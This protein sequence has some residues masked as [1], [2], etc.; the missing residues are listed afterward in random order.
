MSQNATETL[1]INRKELPSAS[2]G[3]PPV[4]SSPLYPKSLTAEHTLSVSTLVEQC[5][6]EI[7]AYRRGEPSNESFGLELLRRAIVQG[8]QDAWIGLQQCFDETIRFWL[9]SHPHREVAC[10]LES[11]NTYV[12]LALERFWQATTGQQIEFKTLGGALAYLRASLHGAILDTLRAYSRPREVALPE[13]G[14]FGEPQVEDQVEGPEVWEALQAIL[15]N[16]R[17]QRLAYLLYHC[18]LKPREIVRFCSQEWSDIHE[19]Y[20]LRRNIQERILRNVDKLRW[21][22]GAH[23][24]K[25]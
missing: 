12:A 3:L 9:Y 7:G 10:R 13:P 4:S 19:I 23:S 21:Q 11:D 16:K 22:L 5:Q 18:G 20:R 17:E 8:D 6:R 15:P 1:A 25:L 14:D 2:Q 24:N